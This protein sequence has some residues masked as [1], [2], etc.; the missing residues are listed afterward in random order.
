MSSSHFIG[1]RIRAVRQ[2]VGLSLDRFA[3]VLGYSRRALI[4]WEQ[5]LAEPPIGVLAKLRYLYDVDPEWVVLGEDTTPQGCFGP[6][7]WNRFDRLM[8]DVDAVCVD[9]GLEL[10]MER[11]QALGRVLYDGGQDA[12]RATCKQLRGTLLALSQGN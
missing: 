7:D 11:R 6:A 2:K 3:E 4:N 1:E 5:N 10:S 9:V 12:G 8:R